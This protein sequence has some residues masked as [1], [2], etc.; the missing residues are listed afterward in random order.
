MKMLKKLFHRHSWVYHWDMSLD[1]SKYNKGSHYY[2]CE[3]GESFTSRTSP[4]LFVFA[5]KKKGK[6]LVNDGFND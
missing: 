4:D 5:N 6:W 3:C 1:D 2:R